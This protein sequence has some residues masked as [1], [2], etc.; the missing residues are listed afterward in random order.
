MC[1]DRVAFLWLARVL[2]L[3]MG[4]TCASPLIAQDHVVTE[5]PRSTIQHV[6]LVH[7]SHTDYGYS[8]H[9]E[10]CREMQRRYL[11]IAIDAVLATMD[12]PPSQKF[13]WTAE[14]TVAVNDWWQAAT[15]ERRKDFLK[16]VR[17]G[18]LE[19]SALPLNQTPTLNRQEW[20][21]MLHW[22]PE[23]LWKDVQPEVAL[24][25]DVNGFPRAG[26]IALL[27][28]DIHYLFS[29]IN[30]ELGGPPMKVPTAFW[31]KMPDNRK[32]FVWLSYPYYEGS[33]FFTTEDWRRGYPT[34]TDTRYRPPRPGEIFP[35]DEPAVRKAHQRLLERIRSLEA[36]G[37][38]HSTL[39]LS[40]MNQWRIDIDPPFP[41][42]AE[43]VGEWNR[44]GL[45]PSLRLTTVAASM[46]RLEEE[47]GRDAPVYEGEWT[48]WWANG[49]ASGP[50]ELSASRL[51]KRLA[52]AAESPLWGPVD[53]NTRKALDGIYRDLCLFDEHTWGYTNS[54]T[55]PY[56]LETLGEYNEKSRY[57]Y[58]PLGLARLLLSQRIRTRLSAEDE[59]VYL[60]N[61]TRSPWSGWLTL[62]TDC[63]R[64]NYKSLEDAQSGVKIPLEVQ[65]LPAK[66]AGMDADT[67]RAMYP[68]NA[69]SQTARFW[70]EKLDAGSIRQL[71]LRTEVEDDR[72]NAEVA[73]PTV[74]IDD[75]GWPTRVSWSGMTKPLFMP[76]LGDV[77]VVA[78]RGSDARDKV[79]S[80][81]GTADNTQRTKMREEHLEETLVT[82]EGKTTVTKNAHTTVYSQVLRHPGFRWAVRQLEMWNR[83]PQARL[84]LRFDR[85]S[86]MRPEVIYVAFTLPCKG[87]LP[88]LS[89]GGVPFVPFQDQLPGSCRDYF[90]IDSWAHYQTS[91]GHWLWV[92][93]DAPLV[94][95]GEHNTLAKRTN[96][97][98]DTHRIFAM[99]FNN[100]WFTNFVGDSHGVME[101]Q[102]DVA[103]RKT[104]EGDRAAQDLAD[105]LLVE[106]QMM[107]NP[108][109]KENPIFLHRLYR[110]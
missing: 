49:D 41:P 96:I 52:A 44:L 33:L 20:Q 80:I 17:S 2:V 69:A 98:E 70:V 74:A 39:L 43:F 61:T 55:L 59:G 100:L 83:E 84:T 14:T 110:P 26:A 67:L 76:G 101:F 92:S 103:W 63:L 57:A 4:G 13:C 10:V 38:A 91:E 77:V 66:P 45:K 107:V 7:F 54:V 30:P 90:A 105:S 42:L 95:I 82:P 12:K 9:P 64:G 8:D 37:Y 31:W 89:N 86:S 60:A 71:R 11:D 58:R 50:R 25:N 23:D 5:R 81:W 35:H 94:A 1:L 40:V 29:G 48:D 88:Q 73:G 62:S 24:Q 36:A 46:K 51:A 109:L 21:T 68:E 65:N 97:P 27:D 93:R 72:K 28:R 34:A 106:P 75:S 87:E 3:T 6:D 18:Q 16:A 78:V 108:R 53:D 104:L 19:V 32:L 15:P 102:F 22:L 85:L 56:D 79:R 99:V 47:V